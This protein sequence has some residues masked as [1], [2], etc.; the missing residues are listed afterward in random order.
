MSQFAQSTYMDIFQATPFHILTHQGM[1]S[2][3]FLVLVKLAMVNVRHL[4]SIL[5]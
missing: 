2:T 3:H 1:K 5:E 4:V